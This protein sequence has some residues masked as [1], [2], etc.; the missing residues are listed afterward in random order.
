M[1]EVLSLYIPLVFADMATEETVRL[2]FEKQKRYGKIS[3]VDFVLK[4]DGMNYSAYVHFEEWERNYDTECFMK[5]VEDGLQ[6]MFDYNYKQMYWV[7]LKNKSA[8]K[9]T[10]AVRIDISGL[11]EVPAKSEFGEESD[12]EEESWMDEILADEEEENE[13]WEFMMEEF[14][15]ED[16]LEAFIQADYVR[17]LEEEINVLRV[18]DGLH[19]QNAWNAQ[20]A[21]SQERMYLQNVIA[22]L[23]AE[24]LRM[25]SNS[26]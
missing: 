9:M 1:S 7:C 26:L 5:N 21:W 3:H 15:K 2:V 18:Q 14:A 24:N 25:L 10:P 12:Y 6:V 11:A 23:Q 8:K 13:V 20:N 4:Q 19:A 17:I 16:E 22:Y